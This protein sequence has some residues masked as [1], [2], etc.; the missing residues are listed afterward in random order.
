MDLSEEEGEVLESHFSGR[1]IEPMMDEHHVII[2]DRESVWSDLRAV[3]ALLL[4]GT[5]SVV[6]TATAIAGVIMITPLKRMVIIVRSDI[7]M[8]TNENIPRGAG[9]ATALRERS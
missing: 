5:V 1:S 8:I 9:A 2:V 6:A 7:S 3:P 4:R